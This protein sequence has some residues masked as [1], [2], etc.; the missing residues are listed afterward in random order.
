M[1]GVVLAIHENIG[2]ADLEEYAV[3]EGKGRTPK[4]FAINPKKLFL[5][6]LALL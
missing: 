5:E 3:R 2:F 1:A 4:D 6:L